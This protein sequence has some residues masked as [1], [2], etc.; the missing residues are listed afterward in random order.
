MRTYSSQQRWALLAL[1]FLVSTSS[2]L[3]RYVLSVVL[4]SIKSQFR[5][6]DTMLGLL[7]G[8]SFSVFYAVLGL[9]IARW[10]DRGNR[11]T[12]ITLALIVWSVM[13]IFSG[14]AQ[15]F[16]QLIVA[17]IGVGAGE[18]GTMPP[19]QSLISDYFPVEQRARALGVFGSSATAGYLLGLGVG[20]TI[21]VSHGWQSA[22]IYP[23]AFGIVL[24]IVVTLFL[25][26]P[27]R[28]NAYSNN[29][30]PVE[31]VRLSLARLRHKGSFMYALGGY[32]LYW[33]VVYGALIFIPSF[34]VRVLHAPF[35][36][37]NVTYG[38]VMALSNA[39]GTVG[40]GWAADRLSRLDV[41]WL[42]W[43]PGVTCVLATP[44]YIAAFCAH[45]ESEFMFFAFVSNVMLAA[46]LTSALT[47]I[48]RVCGSPRRAAAIAIVL[49]SATLFGGGLG[50]LVT[51]LLSDRLG[52][53]YGPGSLRYSLVAMMG[54]LAVAGASF[55]R[56]GGLILRDVE[57]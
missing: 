45:Q 47:G 53:V 23:G 43:V 13:T 48:H 32:I 2:Y 33:F 35:V 21:A 42:G 40:G 1:L 11:R 9:P 19:A 4:E 14:L 54:V 7:G 16:W 28:R 10:A 26:E 52:A 3:D 56:F 12:I 8:F 37:A 38:G 15:S 17:R 36:S 5:V 29:R 30:V 46:G 31:T 24:A 18:A 39:I 55:W 6:S 27:R 51:G 41:R 20:S 57:D 50:P 34:L 44:L 22:F 49:F 25:S